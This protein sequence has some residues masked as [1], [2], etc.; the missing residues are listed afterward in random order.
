[1]TSPS[2]LYRNNSTHRYSIDHLTHVTPV[3]AAVAIIVGVLGILQTIFYENIPTIFYGW[4]P[5]FKP[6]FSVGI[7]I[8]GITLLLVSQQRT[9]RVIWIFGK[10]CA[11]LMILI[12]ALTL[13]EYFSGINL[14]IDQA[15]YSE[16]FGAD[17]SNFPGRMAVMTAG[18]FILMGWAFLVI[19]GEPKRRTISLSQTFSLL[20]V[21]G[22]ATAILSYAY[23]VHDMQN[24]GPFMIFGLMT[25]PAAIAWISLAVGTVFSRPNIGIMHTLTQSTFASY[26]LRYLLI[27]IIIIPPLLVSALILDVQKYFVIPQLGIAILTLLS[28][29]VFALFVW[30]TVAGLEKL[31]QQEKIASDA[32]RR[33]ESDLKGFLD[34]SQTGVALA[35]PRTGRFLRVNRKL[36]DMTGYTESELLTMSFRDLTHPDDD[37]K[38]WDEYRR[39]TSLKRGQFSFEKR[40]IHKNGSIVWVQILGFVLPDHPN[41]PPRTLAFVQDLTARKEEETALQQAKKIAEEANQMKSAFLANMSHELRTPLAAVAGFCDL[42]QSESLSA[43]DRN[44][45]LSVITRNTEVLT[46][47]IDDILDLSKVEAGKLDF[48]MASTSLHDLLRD[49]VSILEPKA[50]AKNIRLTTTSIGDIPS[51]II[52]DALRLKQILMN[53][54]GNAIKFT[55]KGEVSIRGKFVP[56]SPPGIAGVLQFAIMDTGHGISD[57]EKSRLFK[58]FSQADSSTTRKFGGTGLG[59]ILSKRLAMALGGDVE[60]TESRVGEGSTFT[61]KIS[62]GPVQPNAP[63]VVGRLRA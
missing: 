57:V 35:D 28:I 48:E 30:R 54:I 5:R 1:M 19:N 2:K 27:P 8:A 6:N 44:T 29:V 53:I 3:C 17:D 21:L 59:L 34:A 61:I 39:L 13:I 4:L 50:Q 9:T 51:Y 56:N 42:L 36:C 40:Y 58:P 20:T 32:F 23:G 55:D 62:T 33:S 24:K 7:I 10:A 41:D 45:F 63:F 38:Q 52:T 16:P 46:R 11:S 26:S 47:L 12:G 31:E 15:I 60:L 25:I 49:V 18:N 22:P 43:A 37:I 14:H